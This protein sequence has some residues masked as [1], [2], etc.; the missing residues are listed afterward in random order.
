MSTTLSIMSDEMS[1][2]MIQNLTQQLFA[3]L[4]ESIPALK[5]ELPAES[6]QA[7]SK[8]DPITI[9]SIILTL[10]GSGGIAVALV[11][12]LRAYIE[13]EASL[14]IRIVNEGGREMSIDAANLSDDQMER[15]LSSLVLL[16]GDKL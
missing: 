8:G 15:T 5:A 11:G 3:D 14:K 7:G 2:E 16:S 1:D 9:G 13:K 10:I 12:V 6:T 4:N